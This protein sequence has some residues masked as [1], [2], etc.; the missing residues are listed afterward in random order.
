MASPVHAL[1]ATLTPNVCPAPML[2]WG[3]V[4]V[5]GSLQTSEDSRISRTRTAPSPSTSRGGT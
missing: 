2:G 3:T 1:V 4:G 5:M